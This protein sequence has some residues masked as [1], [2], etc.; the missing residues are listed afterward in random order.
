MYRGYPEEALVSNRSSLLISG[1]TEAERRAWAEEAAGTFSEEGALSVATTDAELALALHRTRGVVYVPDAT[2]LS[3]SAQSHAVHVLHEQEERPKLI[4]GLPRGSGGVEEG[5]LRMDLH[6][7]LSM[8]QVNLD[9]P[10]LRDAIRIRRARA[11]KRPLATASQSLRP[12]PSRVAPTRSRPT[13]R[14]PKRRPAART[15]PRTASAKKARG[16][17]TKKVAAR[18]RPV[19]KRRR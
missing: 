19:A 18:K 12:V 9:E 11:P 5:K 6:Y 1:G 15:K 7:A 2:A 13:A 17:R 4:F 16:P 10:G 8:A 14:M 3:D